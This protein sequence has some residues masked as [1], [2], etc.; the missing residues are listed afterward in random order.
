MRGFFVLA[1]CLSPNSR[2]AARIQL[3]DG[4]RH[5]P[6]GRRMKRKAMMYP[7]E[8]N[9]MVLIIGSFLNFL[10]QV[11]LILKKNLVGLEM[12]IAMGVLIF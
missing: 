1:P 9:M 8:E 3:T 10:P 5:M 2:Q 11:F 7:M 12:L 6:V 4:S